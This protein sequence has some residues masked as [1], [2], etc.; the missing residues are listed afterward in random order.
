M[1]AIH[2]RKW[3][4]IQRG[5]IG[6]LAQSFFIIVWYKLYVSI[7]LLAHKPLP[8]TLLLKIIVREEQKDS[9]P[10]IIL[11][12]E[13]IP[14][15]PSRFSYPSSSECWCLQPIYRSHQTMR[16]PKPHPLDFIPA[17]S[18]ASL[19]SSW[20][21]KR[22]SLGWECLSTSAAAT[23]SVLMCG[24]QV[25]LPIIHATL[26]SFVSRWRGSRR[27]VPV[28]EIFSLPWE[29][30]SVEVFYFPALEV[31]RGRNLASRA[32]TRMHSSLQRWD[33]SCLSS[34]AL[35]SHSSV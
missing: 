11:P 23:R 22:R 1:F 8:Y 34:L 12:G 26:R 33:I 20:P 7:H 31:E 27:S 4:N 16:L 25:C 30:A 9:P 6:K 5:C 3:E 21:R 17:S 10:H 28:P 32:S 13:H 14:A 29:P 24:D 19:A 35:P 18:F 2:R 15:S